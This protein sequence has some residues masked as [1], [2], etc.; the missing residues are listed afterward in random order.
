MKSPEDLIG[1]SSDAAVELTE[2][3]H[4][5]KHSNR[6]SAVHLHAL[7]KGL[8]EID[9]EFQLQIL[10]AP[11]AGSTMLERCSSFCRHLLRARGASAPESWTRPCL[12]ELGWLQPT[13]KGWR[14]KAAAAE[15]PLLDW[16][17]ADVGRALWSLGTFNRLRW[18][19][20]DAT[21]LV[22]DI[23]WDLGRREVDDMIA[24]LKRELIRL[25]KPD[26]GM[27][28]KRF[29]ALVNSDLTHLRALCGKAGVVAHGLLDSPYAK[30][31]RCLTLQ[32]SAGLALVCMETRSRWFGVYRTSA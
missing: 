19:W 17:G 10:T 15:D 1:A 16:T 7:W 4:V 14:R 20:G 28:R 27:S 25:P 31:E 11:T 5:G 26:D 32:S 3:V 21:S 29:D 9:G 30:V 24:Q 23:D 12:E 8:A 2:L 22:A 13:R 6:S 18:R